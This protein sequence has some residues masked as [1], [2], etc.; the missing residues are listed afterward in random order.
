[1]DGSRSRENLSAFLDYCKNK[2]MMRPAT[3]EARKAAVNQV[4]G[5]LKDEEAKDVS[6]LDLDLLLRR[7]QNLHGKRYTPESLR[8]YRAR[9]KN[10]IEEFLRYLENPM[11][12]QPRA[13]NATKHLKIGKAGAARLASRPKEQGG[14]TVA[15]PRAAPPVST[16]TL[17]IPLRH[18][19]TVL[20][21][22][23]PYDLTEQEARKIAN[24][25]LAMA[26]PANA[27]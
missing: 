2:G 24:V 27:E 18:D 16:A 3:A 7:F 8:T 19:L 13:P 10:S 23:L 11:D 5:I 17:P 1:M 20:I 26:T 14:D 21:H 22:G 4:L 6:T 15:T 25:M 12:F 9:V